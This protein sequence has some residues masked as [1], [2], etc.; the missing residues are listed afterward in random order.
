MKLLSSILT[1]ARKPDVQPNIWLSFRD[2]S[3]KGELIHRCGTKLVLKNTDVITV[4]P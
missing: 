2:R 3:Q 1:G 4:G